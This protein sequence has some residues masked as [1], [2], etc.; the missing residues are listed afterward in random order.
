[1]MMSSVE[2]EAV[3]KVAVLGDDSY[4]SKKTNVEKLKSRVKE[5]KSLEL[6]SKNDTLALRKKH[7]GLVLNH[8]ECI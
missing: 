6:M 1:M 7:V 4:E 8:V 2:S 3:N 5:M